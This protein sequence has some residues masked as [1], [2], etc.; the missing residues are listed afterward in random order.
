MR[1]E[2]LAGQGAV[3]LAGDAQLAGDRQ[4]RVGVV[5]G[6]HDRADAGLPAGANRRPDLLARRVDHADQADEDQVLLAAGRLVAG[7]RVWRSARA[8]TRRARP[9]ISAAVAQDLA[10]DARRSAARS[11]RA[12]T[13][14]SHL[15]ED[16]LGRPL[17]VH[18]RR[19]VRPADD[20]RH[21]LAVGV[22]RDLVQHAVVSVVGL[23]VGLAGGDDQR[24]L[25]RVAD[26][27]PAALVASARGRPAR[28]CTRRRCAGPASG[29]ASPRVDRLAMASIVLVVP[30]V[31][32]ARAA[33]SRRR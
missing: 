23:D 21:R 13:R 1:V 2:L 25:G 12:A 15:R 9:A 4:R 31:E 11:A 14:S 16:D 19:V 7:V 29:R 27:L 6:D 8:R 28:C 22:E 10:R 17:G 20:D 32:P 26:D 18:R 30:R 24:P 5:A 33:R 3:V